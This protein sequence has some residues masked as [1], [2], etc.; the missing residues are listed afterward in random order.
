MI[1]IVVLGI[2][3]FVLA[4]GP[5][6]A[7]KIIQDSL[8]QRDV[9]LENR[10]KESNDKLTKQN[11][12]LDG[13]IKT[14][15]KQI[16]SKDNQIVTLRKEKLGIQKELDNANKKLKEITVPTTVPGLVNDFRNLGYKPWTAPIPPTK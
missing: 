5:G 1:G 11:K 9:E 6:K 13:K 2:V 10:L 8:T 16:S 12:D 15:E 7:Y 3:G 14:L 4:G